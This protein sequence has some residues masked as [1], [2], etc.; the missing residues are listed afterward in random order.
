MIKTMAGR[1]ASKRKSAR[2][3]GAKEAVS[4]LSETLVESL[5]SN[6]EIANNGYFSTSGAPLQSEK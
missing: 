5:Q 2:R 3:V 6:T 1:R 4:K